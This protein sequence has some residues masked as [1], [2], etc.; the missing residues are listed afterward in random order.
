[1]RDMLVTACAHVYFVGLWVEPETRVSSR[2]LG[3]TVSL[4][5]GHP[6]EADEALIEPM[7][8]QCLR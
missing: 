1:M 8:L 3:F 5:K 2:L 7:S 6:K 4:S